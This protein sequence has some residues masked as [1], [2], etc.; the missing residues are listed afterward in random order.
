MVDKYA[1]AYSRCGF[2]FVPLVTR[3]MSCKLDVLV[4]RRD[5]PYRVIA[6]GDLD[7]LLKTLIDGLR[8]PQQCSELVGQT[9]GK[10]DE[11]FYCLLEDDDGIA[12][13]S[14]VSD[15][16]LVPPD[17][18]EPTRDVVATVTVTVTSGRGG[19]FSMRELYDEE[20]SGGLIVLERDQ[21]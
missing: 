5:E 13:F 20:E 3:G 4:L 14:A 2:K 21:L 1:D 11:P 16:L 8:M 17:A 15:R 18:D 6:R 10:D 7:N 12:E 19:E 9:P